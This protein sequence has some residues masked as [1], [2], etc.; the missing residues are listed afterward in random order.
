MAEKIDR[1]EKILAQLLIITLKDSPL[2]EKASALS[3]AGFEPSE[4][5]ELIGATSGTV[6]QS[7]YALRKSGSK[8][9]RKPQR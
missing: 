3:R 1:A 6:R 7:L 2:G 4:I 8:I 9:K 5:A